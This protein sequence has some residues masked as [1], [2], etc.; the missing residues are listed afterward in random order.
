MESGG[1]VMKTEETR[2]KL[3]AAATSQFAERGFYG[4]SIAQIA[5]EIGL[6]KQ[7]LLYHFKRKDDLYSEVIKRI[8]E[9]LR[10]AMAARIAP[11]GSP[12]W[13]FEEMFM[14]FYEAALANPLDVQILMRELVDNQRQFAPESQWHIR[15]TLNG[16]VA[17]LDAIPGMEQLTF[18]EK[19]SRMYTAVSAVQYFIASTHTLRR[20]YGEEEFA[21]IS[22]AYP[23]ELRRQLRAI[24]TQ[25]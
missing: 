20:F 25:T 11:S 18:A 4:A 5:G 17:S 23:E 7:A 12:E 8:G 15:A 13:Q 1:V 10:E 2:E 16:I 21:Q 6:T 9:R 3:L 22:A 14:G 19:F 24:V